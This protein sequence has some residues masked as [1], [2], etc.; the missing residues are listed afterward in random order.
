MLSAKVPTTLAGLLAVPTKGES[1]MRIAEQMQFWHVDDEGGEHGGQQVTE[2]EIP[3]PALF[4]QVRV[5]HTNDGQ[6]RAGARH[7]CHS[8]RHPPAPSAYSR[9]ALTTANA[10]LPPSNARGHVAANAW[11][12]VAALTSD[13][14]L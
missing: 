1:L 3:F 4:E 11:R 5:T 6:L 2:P 12:R 8:P 9:H 14:A 13:R 10:P 7:A